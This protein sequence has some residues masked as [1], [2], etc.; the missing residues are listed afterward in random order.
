MIS[1]SILF[2]TFFA[3]YVVHLLDETILNG[4]FVHS[5]KDGFWPTY[6]A[7]MFFW[8]NGVARLADHLASCPKLPG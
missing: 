5:I 4:G 8:F 2:W 6:N 1:L 3:T 7:R